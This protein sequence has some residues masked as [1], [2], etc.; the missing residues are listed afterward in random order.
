MGYCVIF[1]TNAYRNLAS[2]NSLKES[3]FLLR[4][5]QSKESAMGI[6]PLMSSTVAMELL[7]HLK[8]NCLSRN[9]HECR[10]S[11]ILMY[12]H[13]SNNG[14]YNLLPLPEVQIA[15]E[16][17]R[18]E[19]K[20]TINT[21]RGLGQILYELSQKCVWLV[22][23][24]RRKD[25]SRIRDF[26][27]GGENFYLQSMENICKKFDPTYSNWK[28]F[29]RDKKKRKEFLDFLKSQKFKDETAQAMLE[30]VSLNLVS[31]NLSP[32]PVNSKMISNYSSSRIV[33]LVFRQHVWEGLTTGLKLSRKKNGNY[34]WDEYILHSCI[35]TINGNRVIIVSSDRKM[36][37]AAKEVFGQTQQAVMTLEDYYSFIGLKR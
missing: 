30:A 19:D 36:K 37:N 33:S 2:S 26:V 7:S 16:F 15:H 24:K 3:K 27:Y 29:Q 4:E 18:L 31:Q 12:L 5:I 32:V 17:F 20:R 11:A 22:R 34:I 28:L 21:Q 6:I 14:N 10:R 1:D 25:I 13:C 9:F 23:W 8:D 35:G